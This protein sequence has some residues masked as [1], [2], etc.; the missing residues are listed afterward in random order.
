V[1]LTV[2]VA[3]LFTAVP[4][5][6]RANGRDA[7]LSASQSVA[8]VALP[9]VAGAKDIVSTL[10]AAR[11]RALN[12]QAIRAIPAFAVA[13]ARDHDVVY[14]ANVLVGDT[15]M[16]APHALVQVIPEIPKA[17][18]QPVFFAQ[19]L[20]VNGGTGKSVWYLV[21]IERAGDGTW[22][23]AFVSFGGR[24]AKAPPLRELT[25]SDS[26][27]PS[28]TPDARARIVRQALSVAKPYPVQRTAKGVVV[29]SHGA[30]NVAT[31]RIYGLALPSGDV[32][33]CFTW[34]T[35]G[36]VTYPAG[37]LRQQSPTYAWGHVL[38]LGD[39]RSVTIDKAVAE[40]TA[41]AG[42]GKHKP[43]LVLQDLARTASITGIRA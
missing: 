21:A 2:A 27:T 1:A 40:C 12:S 30:V 33:S 32:L 38:A 25:R 43:F 10:W 17:S 31:E 41:G 7:P 34:H 9:T 18:D 11:E 4:A 24:D 39:Y 16:I 42:D 23:I 26:S 15:P 6:G 5:Y 19:V 3:V 35:I 22:K 36:T 13:S 20:T 28:I 14:L 8:T 29:R 37:V